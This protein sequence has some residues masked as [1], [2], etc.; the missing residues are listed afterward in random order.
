MRIEVDPQTLIDAGKNVG[1]LG[2]QL[3]AL[4]DAMS[5]VLSSGIASGGDP[6]GLSF[7]IKY[8]RQAD[9]FGKLLAQITDAFNNV[10]VMLEATGFNYQHADQA[11]VAGGAGP[12]GSVSG[13]PEKAAVPDAPYG[14][15]GSLVTPPGKWYVIQPF[16]RM[17][18]VIGIAAGVA[19]TWPSG[20]SGMMN[21]TAA[22]WRNIA[23]GLRVFEP[24]LNASKASVGAQNIPEGADIANALSQIGSSAT[25]LA[26]AADEI[27]TSVSDFA[28][29]VQQ[30]QDAIRDLLN[31]ISLDGLWDTVTGLL[32]GDGDKVLRE[33]ADDVSTV[34]ENFQSQVKGVLGLLD[35]LGTLLGEASDALNRWARPI[36]V[37]TFG[38]GAGNAIAN[39]MDLYTDIQVGG[40]VAVIGLVSGTV[41]LADLDTWKNLA[42]T[43]IMIAKDP[44]KIDD[45]LI[46]SGSEFIALDE[47]K[48]E[49][50]GRGFGEA[51]GNIATLFIPGGAL[52]KGGAVAK[53]LAATRNLLEKGELGRLGRLPGLGG[54]G[55][56]DLPDLPDNPG[57]PHV[58]EF[59]PPPGVPPSVVNPPGG[60]PGGPNGSPSVRPQTGE[61]GGPSSTG[62]GSGNQNTPSPNGSGSNPN[63]AGQG[64]P[65]SGGSAPAG[66]SPT[67]GGGEGSGGSAS[68]GPVPTGGS[69]THGGG[70]GSG[71]AAAGGSSSNGPVPNG[72]SPSA[73]ADAPSGGSHSS[74]SAE[75][76]GSGGPSKSGGGDGPSPVSGGGSESGGGSHSGGGEG[77]GSSSESGGGAH[78]AD[79]GMSQRPDESHS[80][81]GDSSH[82]PSDHP[83][84][85]SR[86]YDSDGRT[87]PTD[88]LAHPDAGLL[89]QG[90]LDDAASKPDRVADAL[91]PGAPSTHPEVQ[92]MV[93]DSYD[94][95]GG[96]PETDW[97]REYWPS[98]AR[99]MH[100][101]P[102]LVWPDSQAHPQGFISPEDRTASVLKPGDTFDRFGP[103]FGQ[104]GSPVG[105]EFSA[106]GLPPNSLD[107]GYHR[108]EVVRPIPIWEGPIAPA[109]G[110]PGGGLQYYFPRS[111]VDLVNAGYLREVKL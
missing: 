110:Q 103:G 52:A 27:A 55:T 15:N 23:R 48:G 78:N 61:P 19:L 102:V 80:P 87:I 92:S 47:W 74:Q 97:N 58:P 69:P 34:L 66:G 99:D 29:S 35:E 22:Q 45:V 37:E 51:V 39:V 8:G 95:H 2:T 90:L 62:G 86:D 71:G 81:S 16:I 40:A 98:G 65:S 94:P 33:I 28:S 7:G 17:I 73:G 4:S 75:S 93:S 85:H 64:S 32:S 18:P 76:S 13:Q 41:A 31:R 30:T 77:P 44:S 20:N 12:T 107:A 105:T 38:E 42:D 3:G 108:Y 82:D 88:D 26:S 54:R 109:M 5:Q 24:A 111:I 68:G 6:A 106:R 10:G 70:E 63:G 101:N 91:S 100:G 14:P 1:A 89:D 21:V 60:S 9:D 36:L 57:A 43:A 96:L 67:H 25:N 79:D 84:Q 56:P 50:P 53:G 83:V 59:T 49:N 11:S 104:F 46:Q 72:G